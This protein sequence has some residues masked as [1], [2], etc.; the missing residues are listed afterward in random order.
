VL[1]A[2]RGGDGTGGG[3]EQGQHRIAG[4]VDD[5][6]VIGLDLRLE[7]ASGSLERGHGPEFVRF[8][9]PRVAGPISGENRGEPLPAPT[10]V[11]RS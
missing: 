3:I 2:Q 4:H 6:A 7:D 11:H 9:E 8:H 10:F 5:M 1:R